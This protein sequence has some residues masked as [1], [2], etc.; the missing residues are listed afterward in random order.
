MK[1]NLRERALR[2]LIEDA[3]FLGFARGCAF[4]YVCRGP[5]VPPKLAPW[6]LAFA[7]RSWPMRVGKFIETDS[8][9]RGVE[10][11]SRYELGA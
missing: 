5:R 2:W 3:P 6:F 11:S 10:V 9:Q 1:S 8:G 4:R 7:L